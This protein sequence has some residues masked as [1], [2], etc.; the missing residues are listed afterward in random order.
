MS[1]SAYDNGYVWFRMVSNHWLPG[2]KWLKFKNRAEQIRRMQREIIKMTLTG[3]H[4]R[5]TLM[6]RVKDEWTWLI[7]WTQK[8]KLEDKPQI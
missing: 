1:T 3:S 4:A 8:L 6:I 2:T 7:L 5:H